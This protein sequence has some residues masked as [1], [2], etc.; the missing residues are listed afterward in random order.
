MVPIHSPFA[1]PP[2]GRHVDGLAARI[3]AIRP[4]VDAHITA[5]R[6]ARYLVAIAETPAPSTA[7][8]AMRVPVLRELLRADGVR[9]G[10]G[11]ILDPNFA[12]TASTVILTGPGRAAKPLWYFAHLD[13]ISYLLLPFDGSR[14]PLVP[15]CYHLVR[16]GSR[17]ARVYRFDLREGRHVAIA[18]G[19]LESEDQMPFFR[20]ADGSPALQAGDRVVLVAEC[21]PG[22]GGQWT[23]HFDNA[24]AVAALAVAAPVLAQAGVDALLAFPDEEE[25]PTGTGSQVMGRGG[26]RIVSLLPAPDLA[27]VADMQQAGGGTGAENPLPGP[28]NSTRLGEGAV[29]SEFSSLARGA[30]TPPA[31]YALARHLAGLLPAA[32]VK[33]QESNNAYTSRS[34]DVSVILKT[35]NILLL[36]FPGFDR[37]FDSAVPRAALSDIVDLSKALVYTSLLQP[38]ARA[39]NAGGGG[40]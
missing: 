10:E 35:P 12:N 33:V 36:G 19:L 14:F 22:P 13:T 16:S 26:S 2:D 20:P 30:V 34:D 4:A 8:S 9:P 15:F 31:L 7:A 24:G 32:G 23:G 18:E 28:E 11:L 21:R 6:V 1:A 29:L 5:E 37:H 27:V 3:E 40:L 38:I 25:G 17:A 39:F